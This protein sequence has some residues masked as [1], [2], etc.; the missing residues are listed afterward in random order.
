MIR[1]ISIPKSFQILLAAPITL[2]GGTRAVVAKESS[3]TANRFSG[4]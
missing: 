1:I 4:Q 3:S 2:E